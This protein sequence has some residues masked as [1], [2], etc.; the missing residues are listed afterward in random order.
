[1]AA[2][3]RTTVATRGRRPA[4][5]GFA[6]SRSRTGAAAFARRRV[7][8]ES[9]WLS[10]PPR[11]C[12]NGNRD[13]VA[14]PTRQRPGRI[15]EPRTWLADW[16]ESIVSQR[17]AQLT[18]FLGHPRWSAVTAEAQHRNGF[19]CYLDELNALV[20]RSWQR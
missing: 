12:F 7:I 11:S 18:S 19:R 20:V 8:T 16:C 15:V 14:A 9:A 4:Q 6:R 2:L 5:Q 10:A 1:M 3:D 13:L 17:F